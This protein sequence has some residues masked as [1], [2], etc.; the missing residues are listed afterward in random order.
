MRPP[1]TAWSGGQGHRQPLPQACLL[2]ACQAQKVHGTKVH[3]PQ[4]S[5]ARENKKNLAVVNDR[6]QSVETFF[7]HLVTL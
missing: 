6:H 5:M 2:Y 1:A 7:S 4:S 3:F